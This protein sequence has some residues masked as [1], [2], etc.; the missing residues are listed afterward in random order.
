MF[1]AS[2]CTG[3]LILTIAPASIAQAEVPTW[4]VGDTWARGARDIDL[5]PI[6]SALIED[7]QQYMQGVHY[8][9]SG[10][11]SYYEIN[12]VAGVDAQQYRLSSTAG[13]EMTISINI[14]GSFDDQ[15]VSGSGNANITVKIDGTL[16]YTKDDL[17][18]TR[19][20]AIVDMDMTFSASGS[21]MGGSGMETFS[22][23]LDMSGN[24]ST[25]FD[26]PLNLLDFPI[27]VGDNW[28]I[29]SVATVTGRLTGKIDMPSMG[30]QPLDTPLDA[31]TSI[32]ISASCPATESFT[33]PNGSTTTAYKIVYSGTSMTGANPFIPASTVYYSPE[34]RFI[35][36][37]ELTFSDAMGGMTA[38]TQEIFSDYTFGASGVENG[39]TLFTMNPVTE[40]EAESA[41]A[42][43]GAEG[44]NLALIGAIVAIVIVAIAAVLVVVRRRHA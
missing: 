42:G 24:L 7:I 28:T 8:T 31:T 26:P 22:G 38:G 9:M 25:T 14:S 40:Q 11:M 34:Q 5:T 35:I 32:S 6:F 12:K 36:A 19:V 4:N 2:L 21:A 33:L 29:S 39:Q 16:Y 43:L 37:E 41:I 15:E 13:V 44:I 17:A 18:L 20:E 23:S 27:S 10:K 1:F 30:E 3:F